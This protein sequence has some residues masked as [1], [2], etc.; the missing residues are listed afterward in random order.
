MS[1]WFVIFAVGGA[2]L[3]WQLFSPW[4]RRQRRRRL[5]AQRFPGSWQGILWR[6]VALYRRMPKVL[7][8]QLHAHI[9]V[10]LAEKTFLGC[11]GLEVNDEMR[12]TIAAQACLL[13]L[14]R[15]TGYYPGLSTVLVYPA[16]FI[17]EREIEEYGIHDLQ[18]RV[19]IGESWDHGKV[20]VSWDDIQASREADE[21]GNV[22]FHEFAHQLDQESGITNGAPVL[23]SRAVRRRWAQIMGAAYQTHCARMARHRDSVLDPYAAEAPEEFFA[24]ATEVFFTAARELR[25]EYPEVYEL[26]AGYYRVDPAGWKNI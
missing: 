26:L 11:N 4:W 17:A 5:R 2:I 19:L 1:L 22:V 18:R 3:A 20:V 24:V 23:E 13:L 7:K 6:N 8:D 14:N 15:D 25:H 9:Q 10:F 21:V 12:V 16:A